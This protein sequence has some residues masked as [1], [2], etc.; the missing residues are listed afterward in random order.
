ML[1]LQQRSDVAKRHLRECCKRRILVYLVS[2]LAEIS[3]QAMQER[4]SGCK[5]RSPWIVA[6]GRTDADIHGYRHC[7]HI[8]FKAVEKTRR[9][10]RMLKAT[11]TSTGGPG[12]RRGPKVRSAGSKSADRA[13]D[14][15]EGPSR[16]GLQKYLQL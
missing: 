7:H 1:F 12:I 8:D 10:S 11:A 5:P 3:S 9:G 6:V 13:V 14:P 15:P 16:P 2:P 4:H